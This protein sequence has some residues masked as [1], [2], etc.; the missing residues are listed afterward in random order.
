LGFLP[1]S[2]L[3]CAG[4]VFGIEAKICA[5]ADASM[6]APIA[7]AHLGRSAPLSAGSFVIFVGFV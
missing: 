4:G 1:G 5:G 6:A 2:G 3:L 7:Q